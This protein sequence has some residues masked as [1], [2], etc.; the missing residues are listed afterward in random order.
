MFKE[1]SEGKRLHTEEMDYMK[2]PRMTLRLVSIYKKL[3]RDLTRRATLLASGVE[4]IEKTLSKDQT[5][6]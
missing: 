2:Q 1:L 6:E 4:K 5:M 3:L